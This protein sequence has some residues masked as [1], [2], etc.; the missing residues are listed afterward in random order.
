MQ[1]NETSWCNE[2]RAG[3]LIA[4]PYRNPPPGAPWLLD[5]PQPSIPV[6]VVKVERDATML[7]RKW[8]HVLGGKHGNVV[9]FNSDSFVYDKSELIARGE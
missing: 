9:K 2:Y 4:I 1:R 7:G 3:D 5:R 6:M 8:Y